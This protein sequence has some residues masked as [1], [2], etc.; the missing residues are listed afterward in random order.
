MN[1]V[2]ACRSAAATVF[3]KNTTTTTNAAAA[4]F[5]QQQTREIKYHASRNHTE[6][7]RNVLRMYRRWMKL[8][9]W[10]KTVYH[11]PVDEK[12]MLKRVKREFLKNAKVTDIP[13][14]D[15]LVYRAFQ[16]F[17]EVEMHHKQR[18]HLLRFFAEAEPA[19]MNPATSNVSALGKADLAASGQVPEHI[20]AYLKEHPELMAKLEKMMK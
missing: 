4:L 10:I 20:A 17:E 5:T 6:A 11:I 2:V 14:I 18:G 3:Q 7:N 19:M 12:L 13:M 16:D 9:P 15:G 1:R 8:I